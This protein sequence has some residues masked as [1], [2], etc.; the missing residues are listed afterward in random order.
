MISS[1]CARSLALA[2]ITYTFSVMSTSAASTTMPEVDR[3]LNGIPVKRPRIHGGWDTVED[4]YSYAQVSLQW[5]EEGHQCGGSLVA[6]DMV[7]TAAHCIG[8]FN[9]IEI[10]KYMK[11]DILDESETFVSFSETMHPDYDEETTRF[12]VMVLKLNET[13]KMGKPVEINRNDYV[14]SDGTILT[15]VGMGYNGDWELPQAVQETTVEYD[16]NSECSEIIDEHGTTLDGDLYPDM[17]CAGSAGKDSCY[18]DSG[19][20]L[21]LKGVTEEYDRQIGLVSWGYECA[22][23]LPGV[24]SRLSYWRVYEFIEEH[25]CLHSVEPPSYMHCDKWS[26]APTITPSAEPT[27][28]PSATPSATPTLSIEPTQTMQPTAQP[29]TTNPPVSQGPTLERFRQASN[30]SMKSRIS[31]PSAAFSV[32]PPFHRNAVISIL[33]STTLALILL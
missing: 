10:G 6:P 18:G 13:S 21:I 14:P 4:R 31:E 32:V 5:G 22:G 24:Y 28:T 17:L 30:G 7:L 23:T 33:L 11:N 25:V 20:P 12:D 27:E 2:W 1:L 26:M 29:T 19:S 3:Q 15:V 8:S 9:K 16:V